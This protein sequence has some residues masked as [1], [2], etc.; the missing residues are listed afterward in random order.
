[1]TVESIDLLEIVGFFAQIYHVQL[2]LIVLDT[3][4]VDPVVRLDVVE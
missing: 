3:K 1:M 4:E 2:D